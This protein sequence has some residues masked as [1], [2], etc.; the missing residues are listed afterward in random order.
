MVFRWA[1]AAFDLS[2]PSLLRIVI[3][4]Y[5][6]HAPP[7]MFPKKTISMLTILLLVYMSIII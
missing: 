6:T 2:P 4:I 7:L 5:L 1:C 3:H